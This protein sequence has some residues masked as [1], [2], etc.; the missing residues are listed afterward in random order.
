METSSKSTRKCLVNTNLKNSENPVQPKEIVKKI[1]KFCNWL[2]PFEI[3]KEFKMA[4]ESTS[5]KRRL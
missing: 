3:P 2:H 5:W 1:L 4:Y